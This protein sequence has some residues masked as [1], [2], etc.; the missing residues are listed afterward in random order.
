MLLF[1][2]VALSLTVWRLV[3]WGALRTSPF[4]DSL[5]APKLFDALAAHAGMGEN[6]AGGGGGGRSDGVA[7]Q[8][9]DYTYSSVDDPPAARRAFLAALHLQVARR[10]ANAGCQV[11]GGG[12]TGAAQGD[13]SAFSFTYRNR[14]VWGQ[15]HAFSFESG[16]SVRIVLLVTEFD[17][18]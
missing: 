16:D 1:V 5:D 2:I 11:Q 15:V 9:F 10:L 6:H 7:T 4:Y 3:D 14:D 17:A 8:E 13:L 18:D 12:S